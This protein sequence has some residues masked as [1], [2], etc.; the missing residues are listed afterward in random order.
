M[1]DCLTP[2]QRRGRSLNWGQP[3]GIARAGRPVRCG[4]SRFDLISR[5]SSSSSPE[6]A[7]SV[8]VMNRQRDLNFS[9]G[10]EYLCG[11]AA[12]IRAAVIV[13]LACG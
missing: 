2:A 13:E 1:A 8:R 7:E 12:H 10:P 9:P 3:A 6:N 4:R 5:P 11:N